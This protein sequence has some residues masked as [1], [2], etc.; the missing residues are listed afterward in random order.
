MYAKRASRGNTKVSILSKRANSGILKTSEASIPE[1]EYNKIPADMPQLIWMMSP[2]DMVCDNLSLSVLYSATYFTSAPLPKAA[3]ILTN[4]WIV[5][6][7]FYSP[8][9][10]APNHL[11]RNIF[12]GKV[13]RI[14][15]IELKKIQLTSRVNFFPCT[16]SNRH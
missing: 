5:M 13:N 6:T 3:M 7:I 1:R 11:A 8:R 10:S 9:S 16:I 14:E 2:E 15:A 4:P 12:N